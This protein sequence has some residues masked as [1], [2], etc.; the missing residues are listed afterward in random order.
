M[1]AL[2]ISASKPGIIEAGLLDAYVEIRPYSVQ[3]TTAKGG[4]LCY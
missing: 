1:F 4:N 2:P 3:W